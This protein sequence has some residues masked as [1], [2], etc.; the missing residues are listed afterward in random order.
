MTTLPGQRV[1]YQLLWMNVSYPFN[2]FC[3]PDPS[4]SLIG[5]L[6]F[7]VIS[8]VD[9]TEFYHPVVYFN[10]YWNLNQ[11]YMPINDTVK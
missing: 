10:D 6:L 5:S 4:R 2:T 9:G 7:A 11:D 8:F 1:M 3:D